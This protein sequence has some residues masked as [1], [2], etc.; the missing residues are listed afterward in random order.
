MLRRF[1]EIFNRTVEPVR[2]RCFLSTHLCFGNYKGRAVGPRRY[3]PMFPAFLDLAADEIH[4]EM[5]SREFA[6]LEIIAEIA[7]HKRVAIGIVDVKIDAH[8]GMLPGPYTRKTIIEHFIK[9]TEPKEIDNTK[10]PVAIDQATGLLWADGCTGPSVTKGFLDLSQVEAAFPKW[11]PFNRGWIERA[12]RGPGRRGG[13]RRTP[14]AYF[15]FGTA[16]AIET[17]QRSTV[18]PA[19]K[20]QREKPS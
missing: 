3:A 16:L 18:G 10:V 9:G 11:Q 14:T 4:L 1:V 19:P 7:A 20:N 13:P 15:S 17:G 2:G 8:S 5:A 12:A 6:E